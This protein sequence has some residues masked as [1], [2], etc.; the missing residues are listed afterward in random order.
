MQRRRRGCGFGV[1]R[2][3]PGLL[4]SCFFLTVYLTCARFGWVVVWISGRRGKEGLGVVKRDVSFPPRVISRGSSDT[5]GQTDRREE[6]AEL[7]RWFSWLVK[8]RVGRPCVGW[9]SGCWLGWRRWCYLSCHFLST[10]KAMGGWERGKGC[11]I[12][13]MG[14][15]TDDDDA[16]V[17][18]WVRG[19]GGG[20]LVAWRLWQA[21]RAGG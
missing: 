5:G 6:K 18:R 13:G 3:H 16:K 11:L 17:H 21:G 1:R 8:R 14:K 20:V 4:S 10:G 7:L 15:G 9:G 2:N 19:V 12:L